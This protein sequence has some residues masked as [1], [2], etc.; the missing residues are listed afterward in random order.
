LLSKGELED[1]RQEF[2]SVP[3]YSYRRKDAPDLPEVGFIAERSPKLILSSDPRFVTALKES[4]YL[5]TVIQAQSN[6]IDELSAS[7]RSLERKVKFL[8]ETATRRT[9]AVVSGKKQ[10]IREIKQSKALLESRL[11]R[12][13]SLLQMKTAALEP[14][15]LASQ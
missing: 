12:I 9:A 15:R 8:A 6:F 7:V 5:A 11:A 13:E 3:L 10:E 1:L 2:K 4:G 14:G